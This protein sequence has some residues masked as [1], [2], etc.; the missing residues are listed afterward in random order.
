MAPPAIK[1]TALGTFHTAVGIV[2]LP[3][4]Y[5]AGLLWDIY[6]PAYTFLFGA[7]VGMFALGLMMV[8][9]NNRISPPGS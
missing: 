1:A 9:K 3:G 7:I 8:V 6:G 2:A 4:G 5:I